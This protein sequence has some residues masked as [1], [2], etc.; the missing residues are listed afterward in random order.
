M[1]SS[2]PTRQRCVILGCPAP[3]PSCG[4]SPQPTRLARGPHFHMQLRPQNQIRSLAPHTHPKKATKTCQRSASRKTCAPH[5]TRTVP[6]LAARSS[7][8]SAAL[9]TALG[10]AQRAS[11]PRT[12]RASRLALQTVHWHATR[13]REVLSVHEFGR[14]RWVLAR[15]ARSPAPARLP[16]PRAHRA[17]RPVV[18]TVHWHVRQC[19]VARPCPR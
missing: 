16:R 3:C 11:R 4:T 13:C 9:H 17:P 14:R 18:Q 10:P 12:Y 1:G 15:R 6:S 19:R 8:T 5:S 2:A 7:R